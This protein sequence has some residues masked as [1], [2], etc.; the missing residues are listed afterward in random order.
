MCDMSG[1]EDRT[2][3]VHGLQCEGARRATHVHQGV[4]SFAKQTV[5]HITNTVQQGPHTRL[6]AQLSRP[7]TRMANGCLSTWEVG[8]TVRGHMKARA[9]ALISSACQVPVRQLKCA[10]ERLQSERDDLAERNRR[11]L[12]GTFNLPEAAAE[13][14]QL[15]RN[16]A[17][18]D[19]NRSGGGNG[20]ICLSAR[21]P[22]PP[23]PAQRP[24]D[25]LTRI[26]QVR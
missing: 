10:W 3:D 2:P 25:G 24:A 26:V 19:E 8:Y 11:Y 6:E 12:A 18:L 13:I 4:A 21:L 16:V 7:A 20:T 9:D 1:A 22:V 17:T 23:S 5:M 15:R 14:D